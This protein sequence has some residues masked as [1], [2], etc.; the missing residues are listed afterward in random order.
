M[1]ITAP[2]PSNYP[3]I[4][5]RLASRQTGGYP[6]EVAFDGRPQAY[7]YLPLDVASSTTY[8]DPQRY[9]EQLFQALTADDRLKA[10]W[11]AAWGHSRRRRI[12]LEIDANAPELH[13]IPWELLRDISPGRAPQTLAADEDTP[14]SRYLPSRWQPGWQPVARPVR[15]LVAV[16][17]PQGLQRFGLSSI[18]FNQE[19]TAIRESVAGLSSQDLVISILP[20]PVTLQRLE[21]ELRKGCD[22]LHILA[23]GAFDQDSG[24]AVLF[25]ANAQDE[26]ALVKDVALA[27]MLARQDD[28]P[29]LVFLASCQGATRSSFDAF[30]G[31]APQLIGAGVPAVL[32]MQGQVTVQTVRTFTSTFYN[33]LLRHGSV[34]LA[35]N[36]ARSTLMTSDDSLGWGVPVLFSQAAAG[37]IIAPR[38]SAPS[39]AGRLRQVPGVARTLAAGG[40]VVSILSILALL[41]GLGSDLCEWLERIGVAP[42]ICYGPAAAPA[43]GFRVGVAEFQVL[44]QAGQPVCAVD[45]AELS[46]WLAATLDRRPQDLPSYVPYTILPPGEIGQ[47][48]G[49]DPIQ[50]NQHAAELA[51]QHSATVLIYGTISAD[52]EGRCQVQ[53]AFH[54]APSAFSYAAEIVGSSRLGSPVSFAPPLDDAA[55]LAPVNKELAARA[56][57]LRLIVAGLEEMYGAI[58]AAAAERFS[59][60]LAQP[61]WSDADGKEV[62]YLLQ[63]AAELRRYDQAVLPEEK[64]Q[65]LTRAWRAFERARQIDSTYARSYLGLGAVALQQA[66]PADLCAVDAGKLSE[67]LRDYETALQSGDPQDPTYVQLA[68]EFGLGQV[69]VAGAEAYGSRTH[70]L[71]PDSAQDDGDLAALASYSPSQA[72]AYFEHVVEEAS[73]SDNPNLAR[74]VPRGLAELGRIER[75]QQDWQGMNDAFRNAIRALEDLGDRSQEIWIA[76]Y[77]AQVG[78]AE[79]MLAESNG[80]QQREHLQRACVAYKQAI[81]LGQGRESSEALAD[82]QQRVANL[83]Q[84]GVEGCE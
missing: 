80:D 53:P 44:R 26:V 50:R 49:D 1:A 56:E 73:R 59:A 17:A 54:V 75:D 11:A 41:L 23:H 45:G 65:M 12:R 29:A 51:A 38:P 19:L 21:V 35:T 20:A 47:V 78:F 37:A 82:W 64:D 83:A 60:A 4:A 55:A 5:I 84:K 39:L 77:W 30:R 81:K 69:H 57:V 31:L 7:G 46:N 3:D 72:Q 22:I 70:D 79:E 42:Q 25:L 9:G 13:T 32:A 10:D 58:F 74:Y 24:E 48:Q 66:R 6:I 36:Q 40:V 71:C 33:D 2:Q 43:Q 76:R 28:P 27:E 61:G 34:D 52:P 16:A 18:D 15:L 68:A 63:G 8:S 67:A 62:G 14:F